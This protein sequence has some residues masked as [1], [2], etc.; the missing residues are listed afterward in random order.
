MKKYL[1]KTTL[2]L[3]LIM[4]LGVFFRSYN[5][6][7]WLHFELDQSRDAMLISHVLEK[8]ISNLPLLGPRAGGTFLRLGPA[9]YYFEYLGALIFGNSPAG[10]ASPVLILS[11]LSLPL[12]YFFVR[13]YF[14]LRLA[15]LLLLLFS[16]SLFLIVYSR[17]AWNPNPLVFF[18]ILTAFC[19]L[20]ITKKGN[21]QTGY[22]LLGLSAA[23]TFTT[24]MHFLAFIAMPT[25][26]F[27]YIVIKR[28]K[29]NWRYWLGAIAIF[30]LLY[31]PVIINDFKTHGQNAK[32]FWLAISGKS[33]K[34]KNNFI[35]KGYRDLT[36]NSLGYFLILTG[37][38]TAQLPQ[39]KMSNWFKYNLIYKD[40]L[41]ALLMGVIAF[42]FFI[43][44]LFVMGWRFRKETDPDKKNFLLLILIWFVIVFGLYL[45]ISSTISPRFFLLVAI[46]PFIL[47][48]LLL[49]SL[50]LKFP[51]SKI[52]YLTYG[53]V[54][55]LV[56][57]NFQAIAARADQLNR[58]SKE[59]VTFETDRILKERYRVTLE[60]QQLIMNY[61]QK[62]YQTNHQPIN[63][64]SK[65]FYR[66][67]F[68][69]HL[70]ERKIQRVARPKADNIFRNVN[71]ILIYPPQSKDINEELYS[72]ENYETV[73]KKQF[74]TLIVYH[75]Q[76]KPDKANIDAII[77]DPL[78]EDEASDSAPQ[79]YEWN[80]LTSDDE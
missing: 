54:A 41:K 52:Q 19:L 30:L 43:L 73:S 27:V 1:T 66:R 25:I 26:C 69:Y 80:S 32:Q 67:A 5:F 36:E 72:A 53:L 71:T 47:F 3:I 18:T 75:L 45:P 51:N 29:I 64:E 40:S 16:C 79:R 56:L 21:H 39:L 68:L 10:V 17:F 13:Q 49:Q 65:P 48:G 62:I 12:F 20:Q 60:Q 24:Q 74:G 33:G 15:I 4:A 35:E 46:L 9:F 37:N 6:S 7:D 38:E 8:G 2:I 34:E 44:S 57:S 59:N 42:M 23:L 11:L 58:A 63:I 77:I 70:D 50:E 14:Q 55:S 78:Q 61:I 31:S 22:W 76:A 28:P